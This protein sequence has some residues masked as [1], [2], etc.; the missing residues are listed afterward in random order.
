MSQVLRKR[1]GRRTRA[2]PRKLPD[3]FRIFNLT[4]PE[5][6][7]LIEKI[8]DNYPPNRQ[9]P[10]YVLEWRNTPQPLHAKCIRTN[11]K[12]LNEP[13]FYM[14]TE[15]TKTK[16]D[17]WWPASEPLVQRPKPPYDKQS[18]QRC[19]FQEPSCTLSRP[20][21]YSRI[22]QPSRGIVPLAVPRSPVS[23]PRLF[24]ERLTFNQHYDARATPCIP[25]QGKKHGSFVWTEIKPARGTA[26]PEGTEGQPC[27]QE[28]GALEQP[29]AEKGRS[30]ENCMSS[31]CFRLPDSQEAAPGSD[32]CLSKAGLR[33]GAKV[34][35]EAPEKGREAAAVP[36][37]SKVDVSHASG[38]RPASPPKSGAR[39]TSQDPLPPIHQTAQLPGEIQTA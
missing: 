37:P 14:D 9:Q 36:Q 11:T 3:T 38:E 34:D 7:N 2:P 15:D 5:R 28:S 29:K 25:Y 24:E 23:L 10:Q 35:P 27:A 20:I 32:T 33:A 18:T 6:N 1:S 39:D 30:T 4:F 8:Q 13:I 12:F 21:K 22:L 16:Q 19:D 31:A 17:C 26:A